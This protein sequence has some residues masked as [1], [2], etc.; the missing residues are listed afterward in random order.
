[1]NILRIVSSTFIPRSEY[2][3]KRSIWDVLRGSTALGS[4]P[5]CAPLHFWIWKPSV[6]SD[7]I[8]ICA[9]GGKTLQANPKAQSQ[10]HG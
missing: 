5:V 2:S 3:E 4:P 7:P 1:M 8:A 10:F 6:W 9:A